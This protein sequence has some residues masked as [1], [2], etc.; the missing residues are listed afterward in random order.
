VIGGLTAVKRFMSEI[1]S[2]GIRFG[3]SHLDIWK[4]L[5]L[6]DKKRVMP[7]KPDEPWKFPDDDGV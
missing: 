7:N 6:L 4:A 3:D 5:K 2:K 1:H